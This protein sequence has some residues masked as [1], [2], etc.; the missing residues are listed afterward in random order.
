MDDLA[1]MFAS[2]THSRPGEVLPA[3]QNTAV[4]SVLPPGW[5]SDVVLEHNHFNL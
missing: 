1:E 2:P 5:L 3:V 4:P